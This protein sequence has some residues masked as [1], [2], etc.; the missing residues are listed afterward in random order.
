MVADAP[1]HGIDQRAEF[2]APGVAF[3]QRNAERRQRSFQPVR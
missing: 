3:W 1:L 2:L